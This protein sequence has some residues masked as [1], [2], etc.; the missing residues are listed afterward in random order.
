MASSFFDTSQWLFSGMKESTKNT[1]TAW[2]PPELEKDPVPHMGE[3][4]LD[5]WGSPEGRTFEA[6]MIWQTM[7]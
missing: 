4:L 2:D 3:M 6:R 5:I 7:S 1:K